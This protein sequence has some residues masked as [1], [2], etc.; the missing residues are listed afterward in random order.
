[1]KSKSWE[2]VRVDLLYRARAILIWTT[3]L[4]ITALTQYQTQWYVDWQI[5]L[6]LA[7]SAL[8]DLLRRL[9]T[10]YTK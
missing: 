1:M 10:D 3:P 2:L 4:I 8:I 6:W 9:K 7:I 5:V